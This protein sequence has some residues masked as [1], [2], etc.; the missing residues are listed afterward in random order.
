MKERAEI[1][2][3]G[4]GLITGLR[5]V[6]ANEYKAKSICPCFFVY[7]YDFWREVSSEV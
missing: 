6:D 1:P 4:E 7:C 5:A 3:V 2:R